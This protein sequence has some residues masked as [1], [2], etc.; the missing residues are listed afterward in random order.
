[1]LLVRRNEQSTAG[2]CSRA[3]KKTTEV[4]TRCHASSTTST[5]TSSP[6]SRKRWTSHRAD[7]CVGYFNLRGWKAIDRTSSDGPAGEGNCCR[8]LVGMQRSPQEELR[9]GLAATPEREQWT[10]RRRSGT[11]AP[12][13]GVPPAADLRLAD[14]RRRSGLR[15]LAAQLRAKKVVVK[16][17]LRH[18]LHAKL[19]LLFRA[20]P[21][22]P[23]VGYPRQQQPDVGRALQAGRAQRRCARPRRHRQARRS[24]SRT[25]GTTAGAS[26]S[27]TNWSRS[28]TRAGR[29]R[30]D[31]AVPHLRQDGLPPVA[32]GARRACASSAFPRDFGNK[33]FEFQTAA[34]KIA[35]H[36]LNKRGGVLIGDVVGLG[37]TLMATALASIF[38][39]DQGSKP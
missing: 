11:S 20:D 36:H 23:I 16:L 2:C 37:K 26:T 22:N 29:G 24:G 4:R 30:A 19:Y 6:R 7:F 38:E 32:G 25:A 17:F 27:R 8:L 12:G 5:S 13:R 1:M 9:D 34:V 35:A 28:S 21:I 14:Q 31:P 18:P 15:R 3:T 33:L 39:D 10:T